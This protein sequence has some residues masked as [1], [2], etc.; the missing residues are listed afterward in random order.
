ME[1][2]DL[3]TKRVKIKPII[4]LPDIGYEVIGTPD[5]DPKS[6]NVSGP[7]SMLKDLEFI[8]TDEIKIEGEQTNFTIEVPLKTT[9]P[10]LTIEDDK[11]VAKITIDIEETIIEKEFKELGISITDTGNSV[12]EILGKQTVD[13]L[14]RGPYSKI[15]ELSS[16]EIKVTSSV[17]DLISKPGKKHKI[18]L[19]VEYPNPDD[20]KLAQITPETVSI[21]IR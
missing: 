11:E 18:K 7:K 4:G 16:E 1:V 12:I 6:V 15:R 17:K 9:S 20:I 10:L 19:N 8:N 5:V 3:I 21:I 13:L 2:D 14:F